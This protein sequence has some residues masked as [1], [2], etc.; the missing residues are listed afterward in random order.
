M[1]FGDLFP[2]GSEKDTKAEPV[3]SRVGYRWQLRRN[4][5]EKDMIDL[6]HSEKL[7]A[8]SEQLLGNG[9]VKQPALD[10]SVMGSC[11]YAWPGGPVDPAT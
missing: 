3:D 6:L 1:R 7:I 8:I 9:M 11:G 5:T 2:P 4:D 10:G